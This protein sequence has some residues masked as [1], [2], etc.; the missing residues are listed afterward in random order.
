VFFSIRHPCAFKFTLWALFL[1]RWYC[2]ITEY[3]GRFS[4]PEE[5]LVAL[6]TCRSTAKG[7]IGALKV[8]MQMGYFS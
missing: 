8:G 6:S 4:S 7:H 2:R 5:P 3:D 1:W